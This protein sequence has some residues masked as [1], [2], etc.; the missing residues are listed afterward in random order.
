MPSL[1]ASHGAG[2][3]PP[4]SA[5]CGPRC[6]SRPKVARQ[7][8]RLLKPRTVPMAAASAHVSHVM[9]D[10]PP[11]GEAGCIVV[12]AHG[13]GVLYLHSSAAARRILSSPG[14]G[15]LPTPGEAQ[16]AVRRTKMRTATTTLMTRCLRSTTVTPGTA[17]TTLRLTKTAAHRHIDSPTAAHRHLDSAHRHL[18]SAHRHLDSWSA[19]SLLR[20]ISMRQ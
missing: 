18:D 7:N 8:W 1:V 13:Q 9:V 14:Q 3:P 4:R 2:P 12:H 5:S 15:H 20:Q 17:T 6:H 11:T 10:R 16:Q 19:T